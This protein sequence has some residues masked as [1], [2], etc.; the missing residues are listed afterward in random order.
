MTRGVLSAEAVRRLEK[1]GNRVQASSKVG[2]QVIKYPGGRVEEFPE[3][4]EG[5]AMIE[6]IGFRP[7]TAQKLWRN[8]PDAQKQTNGGLDLYAH[9]KTYLTRKFEEHKHQ[10]WPKELLTAVGLSPNLVQS[11]IYLVKRINASQR[12]KLNKISLHDLRDWA[13]IKIKKKFYT[14]KFFDTQVLLNSPHHHHHHHPSSSVRG[15]ISSMFPLS[16]R[17]D[18]VPGQIVAVSGKAVADGFYIEKDGQ[19]VPGWKA[20][21]GRGHLNIINNNNNNNSNNVV[22][23]VVVANF[24]FAQVLSPVQRRF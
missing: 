6:Y 1:K 24:C 19:L 16:L 11:L 7:Q 22:M 8:Y 13:I 3:R 5:A 17:K 23:P 9:A 14:M 4:M 20:G 15:V 18:V 10:T 21:K 12:F 2:F